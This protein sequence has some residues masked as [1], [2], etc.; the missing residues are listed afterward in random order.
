V[1]YL[2]NFNH[3]L[4]NDLE[5]YFEGRDGGMLQDPAVRNFRV[6]WQ[7]VQEWCWLEE[8]WQKTDVVSGHELPLCTSS[9]TDIA[10]VKHIDLGRIY[11]DL[12]YLA[13]I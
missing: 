5:E 10:D 2:I 9:S 1:H 4:F 11:I 8:N 3:N 7:R 13:I 12:G 6:Q